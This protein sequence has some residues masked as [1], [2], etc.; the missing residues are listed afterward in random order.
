MDVVTSAV[1]AALSLLSEPLIKDAYDR[2]KAALA[3]KFSKE[4]DVVQA[5]ARLEQK[6]DSAGRRETLREEVVA[7]QADTDEEIV[8]AAQALLDRLKTHH[9]GQQVVQQAVT[10]D[11]NVFS[12]TGDVTV[13]NDG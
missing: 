9:G 13:H 4:S 5:V 12:G 10:G 1:I 11:R 3:G 8:R 6:P 7:S 2:L